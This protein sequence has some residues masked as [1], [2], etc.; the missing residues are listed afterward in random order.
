ML[1]RKVFL[2]LVLVWGANCMAQENQCIRKSELLGGTAYQL[3]ILDK[4]NFV[5]F[6]E[7]LEKIEKGDYSS[8]ARML[9][10]MLKF[11]DTF[12]LS[13]AIFSDTINWFCDWKNIE[14]LN[15]DNNM[16]CIDSIKKKLQKLNNKVA[17]NRHICYEDKMRIIRYSLYWSCL[18]INKESW[19]F[20]PQLTFHR[21][22]LD[23]SSLLT[24][25]MENRNEDSFSI[26]LSHLLKYNYYPNGTLFWHRYPA[27]IFQS[28]IEMA[29]IRLEEFNEFPP[30]K[31]PVC[32]KMELFIQ[33]MLTNITTEKW[34]VLRFNWFTS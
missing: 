18:A 14:G 24:R 20:H 9:S 12:N 5:V 30:S 33:Q 27:R 4:E 19:Y 23:S 32:R 34:I 10:E 31:N 21:S 22:L 28:S 15:N 7:T 16:Y 26:D 25:F 11:F 1:K 17:K 6:T 13:N 8:T 29:L 2:L 3:L